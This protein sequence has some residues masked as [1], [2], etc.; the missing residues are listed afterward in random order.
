MIAIQALE[1]AA[2][3]GLV[4]IATPPPEEDV[5]GLVIIATPPPEA[6]D[7]IGRAM[8]VA[9]PLGAADA[10][11][12]VMIATPPLEAALDGDRGVNK[13][14]LV[15][16]PENPLVLAG[17]GE[18]LVRIPLLALLALLVVVLDKEVLPLAP[19]PH[20][21]EVPGG[22]DYDLVLLQTEQNT[23]DRRQKMELGNFFSF[24]LLPSL[25]SSRRKIEVCKSVT[26]FL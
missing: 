3:P 23:E 22:S 15:V 25:S 5:P 24:Y 12:L 10:T 7:V 1:A 21:Q 2:V 26:L 14:I 17:A 9:Q 19:N 13:V 20:H 16:L 6:A 11:G 4:I 18:V 8:I